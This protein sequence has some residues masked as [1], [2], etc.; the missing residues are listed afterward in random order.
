MFGS[1]R[2]AGECYAVVAGANLGCLRDFGVVP[3]A[4]PYGKRQASL[5]SPPTSSRK[6]PR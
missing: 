5:P 4:R 1:S 6:M 2:V 3:E